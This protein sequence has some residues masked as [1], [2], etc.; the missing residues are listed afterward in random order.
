MI[1]FKGK[2]HDE[3][4]KI[5]TKFDKYDQIFEQPE[6]K[7]MAFIEKN[8]QE[9]KQI[10]EELVTLNSNALCL[11]E[12]TEVI[13]EISVKILSQFLITKITTSLDE[14]FDPLVMINIFEAENYNLNQH[15]KILLMIS[16][17]II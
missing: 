13:N 9:S 17:I 7:N 3:L 15:L 16:K 8:N 10:E 6:E 14:N 2:Y 5:Q 1:N 11:S 12:A 4:T